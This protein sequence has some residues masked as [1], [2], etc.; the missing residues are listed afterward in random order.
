MEAL[1]HRE[2]VGREKKD[3]WAQKLLSARRLAISLSLFTFKT[4]ISNLAPTL[5]II[6]APELPC[7]QLFCGGYVWNFFESRLK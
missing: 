2:S 4:H 5:K 6:N 3:V 1:N 7:V